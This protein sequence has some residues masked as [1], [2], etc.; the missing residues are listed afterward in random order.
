MKTPAEKC[1][2]YR[3]PQSSCIHKVKNPVLVPTTCI[4]KEFIKLLH[5]KLL[6]LQHEKK[7]L[8]YGG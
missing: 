7:C 8:G 1:Q 5:A 2:D 4:L 3:W 6:K